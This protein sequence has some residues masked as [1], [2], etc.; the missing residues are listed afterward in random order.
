MGL[1]R[2]AAM[3]PAV[4]AVIRFK[5]N[6][7][8]LPQVLAALQTQSVPVQRVLAVDTGSGDDSVAILR[9]HGADIIQWSQA[10]HHARVLN[11]AMQH[12]HT[13]RVL[14]LSSHTVME[15]VNTLQQFHHSLAEADVCAVSVTWEGMQDTHEPLDFT[16]VQQAGLRFG[17]IYSN[18][19]GMF[20]HAWWRRFPFAEQ[21]NGVEDYYFALQCLAAGARV[22]QRAVPISY[23]RQGHNRTLAETA[24][25]RWISKQV[26]VPIRWLGTRTA[27]QTLVCKGPSCLWSPSARATTATV[28]RRLLGYH[29]WR[30]FWRAS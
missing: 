7:S 22:H 8:T 4:T 19:L 20:E 29:L 21:L 25:V 15:D 26:Q 3:V 18:S 14:V 30:L 12:V 28:G 23:L 13:P 17:S 10:Y 27:L 5:N 2:L 9:Q 11:F 24:R 1:Y 6:A 16:A